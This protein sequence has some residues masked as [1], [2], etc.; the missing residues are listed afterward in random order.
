M[1]VCIQKMRCETSYV[2]KINLLMT[3]LAKI[4]LTLC[5]TNNRTNFLLFTVLLN[6]LLSHTLLLGT[7]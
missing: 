3:L 4:D 5:K 1:P 6:M 7:G 2:D